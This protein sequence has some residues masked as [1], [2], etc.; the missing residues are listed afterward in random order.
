MI[1]ALRETSRESAREVDVEA[2]RASLLESASWWSAKARSEAFPVDRL[3]VRF[4]C[5]ACGT[6][7]DGVFRC[8]TSPWMGEIGSPLYR[9]AEELARFVEDSLTRRP[10]AV[11]DADWKAAAECVCKSPHHQ[12]RVI[13]AGLFHTV[14][15]RATG[16]VVAR[17]EGVPDVWLLLRDESG[18]PDPIVSSP[19][20][21][22]AFLGRPLTLFDA[23]RDLVEELPVREGTVIGRAVEQGVLLFAAA[24]EANLSAGIA[25]H[26]DASRRVV[27]R[28]DASTARSPGWP[29]SLQP[30]ADAMDEG[31]AVALVLERDAL[32]AQSRAWARSRLAADVTIAEGHWLLRTMTGDW[33]LAP[34]R[35]ALSMV[36][37]GRTL[38]E[39]CAAE[40][41]RAEEALADRL[42]TLRVLTSLVP[43]ASFE[44][45]GTRATARLATGRNG[46]T[47]EVTDIPAGA[48][49]LSPE[50]LAREAAFLFDVAPPWA[51]RTRVCGCGAARGLERRLVVWPWTGSPAERP[52]A[53]RVWGTEQSPSAA[54]V[55]ALCCDRHARIPSEAE[56]RLMGVDEHRLA[57]SLDSNAGLGR[58]NARATVWTGEEHE[59][60]V[61]VRGAMA[62][63]VVLSDGRT[64]ALNDALG[65]PIET[66][67]AVAWAIGE[68]LLA[69]APESLAISH[70][71]LDAQLRRSLGELGVVGPG[72]FWIRRV[73]DLSAAPLGGFDIVIERR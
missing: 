70:E 43:G 39:A 40:L 52:W 65:R 72:A 47:I 63:S 50:D 38:A 24:G 55:V 67:T 22:A 49:A 45:E 32:L 7:F 46:Q 14:Y 29:T 28:L 48:S 69:L 64:R 66:A 30:L 62:S 25:A 36:R 1:A 3:W 33:P 6:D 10:S 37:F 58:S 5:G 54:E 51:D 61:V 11:E 16:L 42:E 4:H 2:A 13:G 34:E 60:I 73:V 20:E 53:I 21:L 9:D 15:G 35:I 26:L 44:V 31:A 68:D 56:L 17:I 71:D 59:R 23:W 8:P 41:A 19:G 18:A 12:R 57:S 27:V